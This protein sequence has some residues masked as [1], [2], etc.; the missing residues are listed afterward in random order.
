MKCSVLVELIVVT[1][2]GRLKLCV[3]VSSACIKVILFILFGVF[4]E[5]LVREVSCL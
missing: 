2:L 1:V 4:I 5:F 3:L